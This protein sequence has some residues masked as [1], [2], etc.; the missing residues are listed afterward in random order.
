MTTQNNNVVGK[1][2]C[3]EK[4]FHPSNGGLQTY[5]KNVRCEC[6]IQLASNNNVEMELKY[7]NKCL[8]M[9]NHGNGLCLKC[10]H[11]SNKIKITMNDNERQIV[12]VEG[13]EENFKKWYVEPYPAVWKA[14]KVVE[15]MQELLASHTADIVGGIEHI[16][17][18]GETP[19]STISGILDTI[20]IIKE[21]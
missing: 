13:W 2:N 11:R 1:P 6:H 10:I 14:H 4:C 9:T 15:K 7:C 8:Q 5:C 20:N 19:E 16:I 18:N 21:K 3:C 17:E 12:N